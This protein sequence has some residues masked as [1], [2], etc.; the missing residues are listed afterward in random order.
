VWEPEA[1]VPAENPD[2]EED[3]TSSSG[4]LWT[5]ETIKS[6]AT[7]HSRAPITA[8]ACG[9]KDLGF[10]CG[11]DDGTITVHDMATSKRLRTLPGH[12]SEMAIIGLTW[13]SS[14][15]FIASGDDS[16]HILVRKVQIPTSGNSK[17]TAYKPSDFRIRNDG[18]NQLLFSSNDKYLL[19]STFSADR[20][21]DVS[22]KKICHVRTHP[23]PKHIK[24]I[25]HPKD[26][27]RLVSIDAGEVHIFDWN[28]F[29]DLTQDDGLRFARVSQDSIAGIQKISNP[30]LPEL[31]QLALEQ[32]RGDEVLEI[33]NCIT[34]T[35]D[36]R[37]IIFET[38]RSGGHDLNKRRR[39]ELIRT[40]DI[41]PTIPER[42]VVLEGSVQELARE[43]SKL[44]GSYQ[45]QV[46][47][48]NHQHWLCT[49]EIGT[50]VENY[51]RHLFLPKDWI[52]SETLSL[53]ALNDHG[54][55]LCPKNGEVAIIK[56]GIRF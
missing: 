51:K 27:S 26:P 5:V 11:R 35:R 37:F 10:C 12:A 8:I 43:V 28:E 6:S 4:S 9:P 3:S 48:F 29:T 47:F 14:G 1:L 31:A 38:L 17:M 46:V 23:S 20:I 52:S 25:E 21:W 22:A 36:K 33:V 19:I 30:I 18:I 54:T 32:S 39:I 50:A 24:W 15:N 55:L 49:W 56:N 16:G 34:H 53:S 40:A 7:S 45:N 44:V 13:S 42:L 41:D 2:A